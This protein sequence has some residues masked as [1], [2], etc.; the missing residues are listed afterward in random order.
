[1]Q[2]K[3]GV[4]IAIEGI[5]G[6]GKGTQFELLTKRL[7]LAGHE[8]VQLDFVKQYLNGA[9]G[10]LDEVGPYT[11]SLFYALDRYEAANQIRE[12]LSEGKVVLANRF[13]GS[14]MA[15]QG[16]KFK[17]ADER[18]GFFIWLD[19]LE[20]EMLH[21]PRPD[22]NLVLR[23]PAEIA[24]TLIDKKEP[25]EYTDKKRDI[26]E[27]DIDHLRQAAEVYDDMCQLFP[28]DYVR[29]DSIRGGNMLPLET[30]SNLVWEKVSPF[31]PKPSRQR[32][33]A[34]TEAPPA[35]AVSTK[36]PYIEKTE[37]G[38]AMTDMGRSYLQDIVTDTE[39]SVYAFTDTIGPAIVGALTRMIK[40]GG[41]LRLIMLDE[42]AHDLGKDGKLIRQVINECG[43]GSIGQLLGL[44]VVV[45]N[46][47]YL[48]ADKLER[49][50]LAAYVEQA[51]GYTGFDRKDA[52]GQ[53]KYVVPEN[54]DA[55]MQTQ[56]RKHLDKIFDL[57]AEM[58]QLLADHI[59]ERASIPKAEQDAAWQSAV[60]VQACDILRPA[61]P[62]ATATTVGI[63]ASAQSIE[64]LFKR[65]ANDMLP[66]AQTTAQHILEQAQKAAPTLF[67]HTED[68]A[69][70]TSN[71]YTNAAEELKKLVIQ[72]LPRNHAEHNGESVDMVDV[73]PRNELQLVPDMLYEHSNL[74]LR[75][76]QS[77]VDSWS[78]DKKAKVF[79]AYMG[80][81]SKRSQR[82]GRALEKI[83]YAWDI[84]CDYDAFR[85]L[86]RHRM[87]DDLEWQQPTPRYGYD[88]PDEV[89]AAGLTEMF[90]E[91][92]DTS[93]QLY[94]VL[95]QAGYSLEAQYATLLGHKMRWKVVYNAREAFHLHELHL[96]A[97]AR[98]N[99]QKIVRQMHEKVTE[100]H[101]LIGE[102]MRFIDESESSP[103][104][105]R[106][107]NITNS[108]YIS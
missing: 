97:N 35:P 58:L 43:D 13:T 66:E 69:Q 103:E 67:V 45:E 23:V 7:D 71:Y 4:F 106:P 79:N 1:M 84:F 53:Y 75:A 34:K 86:K 20:F 19:N 82:P 29:I 9:Y 16:T 57:Y 5:D 14:S 89:E 21:I 98:P 6:A 38:T 87:V 72:Y 30:I 101:P 95:Q 78:Y 88:V 51:S 47:S 102:A 44:H 49:G 10:S 62:V 94:S 65:L 96:H 76:L 83:F 11:A 50:R 22:L 27:A 8:V 40:Q 31:L 77:A 17:N 108:N 85:E 32:K 61:L 48:L 92:F 105:N 91:C 90:E 68:E 74:S 46:T 100:M 54:M 70:R 107:S 56:Y 26:H 59:R 37:E 33:S 18:R 63:F 25:R 73:W 41:D 81:R 15:H 55:E 24:Q 39:G 60:R 12:A 52:H 2:S 42:F 64:S 80:E 36:N 93:L 3:E 28:R 104:V 99:V